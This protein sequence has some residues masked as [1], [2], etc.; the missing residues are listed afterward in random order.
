MNL[1]L[2]YYSSLTRPYGHSCSS[3]NTASQP[4]VFRNKYPST[5][6]Y[7]VACNHEPGLAFNFEYAIIYFLYTSILTNVQCLTMSVGEILTMPRPHIVYVLLL[8]TIP[9]PCNIS[10]VLRNYLLDDPSN[11]YILSR[12]PSLAIHV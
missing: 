12:I 2:Y 4:H 1:I 6:G 5:R 10:I 3:L 9:Q 8:I 7:Y 11:K